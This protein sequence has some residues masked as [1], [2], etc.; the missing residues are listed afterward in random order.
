MC[1][2]AGP[3]AAWR[4]PNE[5]VMNTFVSATLRAVPTASRPVSVRNPS[6][7]S[8]VNFG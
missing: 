1:I 4:R 8:I 5:P 3:G 7:I 6:V 2:A